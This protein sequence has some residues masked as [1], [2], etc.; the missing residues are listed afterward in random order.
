GYSFNAGNWLLAGIH[1]A[2]PNL[3][4]NTWRQ[5]LF[6]APAVGGDPKR[7]FVT[8]QGWGKTT[9][10]PFDSYSQGPAD[11]SP[12][13]M[14]PYSEAHSGGTGALTKYASWYVNDANG[15]PAPRYRTGGSTSH[16]RSPSGPPS[17]HPDRMRPR[18][19]PS[20]GAS[21]PQRGVT[22]DNYS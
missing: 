4:P 14:D 9:G 17:G 2:G 10:L 3:S 21:E 7:S 15:N 5:G 6:S 13:F 1:Y 11:Y 22:A 12:F 8:L 19:C 16:E 18:K 20:T